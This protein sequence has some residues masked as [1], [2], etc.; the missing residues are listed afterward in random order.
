MNTLTTSAAIAAIATMDSIGE[1]SRISSGVRRHSQPKPTSIADL[2][3]GPVEIVGMSPK[4]LNGVV[5]TVDTK[6]GFGKYVTVVATGDH[7]AKIVRNKNSVR[8]PDGSV[9][10]IGIPAA[11]LLPVGGGEEGSG[12]FPATAEGIADL[13]R[14][15][16]LRAPE[17]QD[18][19]NAAIDRSN[20][21]RRAATEVQDKV[22]RSVASV[23]DKIRVCNTQNYRIDGCEGT[24][25]ALGAESAVIA[26]DSGI[27]AT[28]LYAQ[29]QTPEHRFAA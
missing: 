18:I 29:M 8:L 4:Y 5:C 22:M 19:V 23:G 16:S 21:L 10:L 9:S 11:C 25:T 14:S 17:I 27:T 1:L 20:T 6:A 24:I 2:T 15:A 13:C 3:S 28:V 7:A 12:N 26:M